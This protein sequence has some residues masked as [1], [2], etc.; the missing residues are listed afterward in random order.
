MTVTLDEANTL[1]DY[2]VRSPDMWIR[3]L[4]FVLRRCVDS[5]SAP[6]ERSL[7]L[8]WLDTVPGFIG[9]AEARE[10]LEQCELT[11]DLDARQERGM[12]V[13]FWPAE[14]QVG[15]I[16]PILYEQRSQAVIRRQVARV[17]R[18]RPRFMEG[19]T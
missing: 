10:V 11:N 17:R 13:A 12:P 5:A 7:K 6:A 1:A 19:F 18:R 4:G 16:S 3:D 14:P 8:A 9:A 15:E 2:L